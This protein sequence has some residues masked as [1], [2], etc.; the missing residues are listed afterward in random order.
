MASG[1]V[2]G[3]FVGLRRAGSFVVGDDA[4]EVLCCRVFAAA[5]QLVQLAD[6]DEIAVAVVGFCVVAGVDVGKVG[7]AASGQRDIRHG[8]GRAVGEDGVGVVGGDA[9]G[10]VHGDGVAQFDVLAQVVVVEDGAGVVGEPFGGHPI[11]LLTRQRL[12]LRT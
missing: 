7:V 2:P 5:K 9:L 4:A 1:A 11:R 8:A 6:I 3:R 10:G 12:P